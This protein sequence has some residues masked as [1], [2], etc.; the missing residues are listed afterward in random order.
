MGL[1][2]EVRIADSVQSNGLRPA[3]LRRLGKPLVEGREF[4]A[5]VHGGGEMQR[6]GGGQLGR[7]IAHET[8]RETAV[9]SARGPAIVE[10]VRHSSKSAS[11]C[12]A[13]CSL[14]KVG[15]ISSPALKARG[16]GTTRSAVVGASRGMA[17]TTPARTPRE[18]D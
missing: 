16:R 12:R 15:T 2:T 9:R 14:A 4:R 7:E 10:T 3:R 8:G 18:S 17:M 6:V 13:A 5:G 1:L 11:A